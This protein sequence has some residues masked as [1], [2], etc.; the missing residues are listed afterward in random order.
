MPMSRYIPIL[1]ALFAFLP[2]R[3]EAAPEPGDPA[4]RQIET[5]YA[6]LIDNMKNGQELGIQGRYRQLAPAAEATFD[7]GGMARLTVGPAWASM[8][9]ADHKAITDAFGRLTLATYA[10]NFAKFGGEQFVVDPMVKMRNE[11]KIIESKLVRP[12]RPAVPFNY[13]MHL[14]GDKWKVIDVYLNGY[15]SQVALRRA[16]FSSTVASSGASGLVTKIDELATRQMAG[17]S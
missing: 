4:V 16:D 12:G 17:A 13:R 3:L 10:K 6:A 9:E 8:S 15:V 7:L 5:F 11:D 1:M 2:L 14:E